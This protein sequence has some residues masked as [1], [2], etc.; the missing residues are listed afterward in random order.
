MGQ[1]NLSHLRT[2]G[3]MATVGSV[4]TTH[5]MDCTAGVSGFLDVVRFVPG[6]CEKLR[7]L[8]QGSGICGTYLESPPF[9]SMRSGCGA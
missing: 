2:M 8:V 4:R 6:I 1:L 3:I 5:G 9:V 7:V